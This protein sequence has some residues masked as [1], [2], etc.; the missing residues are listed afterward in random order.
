MSLLLLTFIGCK[1][2]SPTN[3]TPNPNLPETPTLTLVDTSKT[4]NFIVCWTTSRRENSYSLQEDQDPAFSN[5]VVAYSEIDTTI[6]ISSKPFS[7]AF[8][9]RVKANNNE[10][11][12]GWSATNSIIVVQLPAPYIL[13]TT[14]ALDFGDVLLDTIGTLPLTVSNMGNSTLVVSNLTVNNPSFSCMLHIEA[15]I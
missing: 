5:P 9:Y 10:G 6:R 1:E 13:I 15:D 7:H 12:R 2:D 3:N 4:G 14:T 8:Y 11:G